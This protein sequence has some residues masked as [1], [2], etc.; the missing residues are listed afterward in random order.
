[1]SSVQYYHY[2]STAAANAIRTD[3]VIRSQNGVKLSTLKPEDHSRDDILRSVYGNTIPTKFKNRADNVVYVTKSLLDASKLVRMNPALYR[4]SGEIKV[5][6]NDVKDK[7]KCANRGSSWGTSGQGSS[8]GSNGSGGSGSENYSGTLYYYTNES[9]ANLI[10]SS[11]YIPFN[12]KIFLTTMKPTDYFRDEILKIIYGK[13]YDRQQYAACADWCIKV[14][15]T[16]LDVNKLNKSNSKVF[17]YADAIQVDPL[18]VI[19]KPKCN[20]GQSQR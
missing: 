12:H 15:S 11:G 7:V 20:K 4:Y 2:T 16:T 1:M 14:D 9:N 13:D 18:D 6:A 8:S 17:E 5:N 3:G 19:D 10:M